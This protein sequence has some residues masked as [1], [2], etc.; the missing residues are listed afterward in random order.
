MQNIGS[1]EPTAARRKLSPTGL[2][3]TIGLGLV[4]VLALLFISP[5]EMANKWCPASSFYTR[6]L[7]LGSSFAPSVFLALCFPPLATLLLSRLD[8]S[9]LWNVPA[10]PG[11]RWRYFTPAVCLLACGSALSA[12]LY[13]RSVSYYYC[14]TP[15]KIV[16]RTG[17]IA[18]PHAY[19]WDDVK[20]VHGQCWTNN[21]KGGPFLGGSINLLLEGGS[22]LSINLLDKHGTAGMV[23]SALRGKTY[24]YFVNSTVTP[25]T[26]PHEVYRLLWNWPN[27][28]G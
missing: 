15:D 16:V 5:T 12:H 26:C 1:S 19:T 25:D 8:L 6:I 10:P 2:I 3:L 24:R 27:D 18:G 21:L 20:E 28:E 23:K 7:R 9:V 17:Y 13:I 11:P 4:L 14:L 22:E